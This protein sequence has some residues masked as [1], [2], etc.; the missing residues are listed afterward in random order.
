MHFCTFFADLFPSPTTSIVATEGLK[1]LG[2]DT[3][4]DLQFLKEQDLAGFLKPIEARKLIA[5]MPS[6]FSNQWSAY[7][8][9]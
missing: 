7:T 5:Q 2:V 4:D 8:C 1:S 6:T 9:I 3:V